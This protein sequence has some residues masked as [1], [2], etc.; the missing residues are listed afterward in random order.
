MRSGIVY[1]KNINAGIISE[2]ENGFEFQYL[3]SYIN[4]PGAIAISLTLPLQRQPFIQK[5]M[6]PFFDGLIPE[7]WMLNLAI[8]NWKLNRL[9]R[10]GLLLNCCGDTIGAVSIEKIK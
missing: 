10:M 6:F 2:T 4:T 8:K 9:D 5:T 3:E 7:G 1:F